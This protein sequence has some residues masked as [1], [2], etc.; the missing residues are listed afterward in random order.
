[1]R[2]L[3]SK[4]LEVAPIMESGDYASALACLTSLKTAVDEFF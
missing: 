2:S 4:E 1:M 3:T